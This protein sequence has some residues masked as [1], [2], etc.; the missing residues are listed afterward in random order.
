MKFQVHERP[1][2]GLALWLETLDEGHAFSA[3][4]VA[5]GSVC[6]FPARAP[7][8]EKLLVGSREEVEKRL[9]LA[10]E[11]IADAA[12]LIDDHEGSIEYKRNLIGIFLRRVFRKAMGDEAP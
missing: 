5:V 2:L 1:T 12:D 4:R 6:P 7:E 10:G 9:G 8:A 3:T 11:A